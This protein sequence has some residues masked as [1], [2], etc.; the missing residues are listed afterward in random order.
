[1]DGVQGLLGLIAFTT[2][3]FLFP[4]TSQPGARGIDKM[5]SEDGT[6][7]RSFVFI[8]PLRSLWLLRS[9]IMFLISIIVFASMVSAFLLSV[10][11]PYT[12]GVRYHIT[13]EALIGACLL[14]SGIGSMVGATIVGR[15]SDQTVIK[16]RRKRK[17]L[18]YPE[19][20]LR[21]ALIPFAIIV[22]LSVFT[23]GLVNTFVDG[24]LGLALCLVCLF[25]TGVGVDMTFGACV[26]YLVD[27][28][29]SRSSEMLATIDVLCSTLI[30]LSVAAFLPMINTFGIAVTNVLC[31][32]LVW[33]TFIGLF[34]IVKYG[35]Q[36]RAWMDIG[37]SSV[38]V[39]TNY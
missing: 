37:F 8:N 3:Y 32:V 31:A 21:A 13:N 33:I 25:S 10:P 1:M 26:A 29:H 39:S 6:S 7:S 19:D 30:A 11:M 12:I 16:W 17:G 4:E 27:V 15:I 34:C 22:P 14:P 24:K 18:W 23:F 2:I 35:N 5:K 20:R 38:Q 36:M 28:M 9:P